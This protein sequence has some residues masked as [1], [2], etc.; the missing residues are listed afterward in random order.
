LFRPDE[1]RPLVKVARIEKFASEIFCYESAA[2]MLQRNRNSRLCAGDRQNNVGINGFIVGAT[3]PEADAGSIR[4]G[5][6]W[7]KNL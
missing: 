1:L 3:N 4:R 2:F 7:I 5:V 6:P